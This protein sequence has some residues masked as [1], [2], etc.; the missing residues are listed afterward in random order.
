MAYGEIVSIPFMGTCSLRPVFVTNLLDL[1]AWFSCLNTGICFHW[2]T[3]WISI[4]DAWGGCRTSWTPPLPWTS[5]QRLVRTPRASQ[6]TLHGHNHANP[7]S[8]TCYSVHVFAYTQSCTAVK[9][10]PT[11]LGYLVTSRGSTHQPEKS[12]FPRAAP[13]FFGIHRDT[14]W[15]VVFNRLFQFGLSSFFILL[16][17]CPQG[18]MSYILEQNPGPVEV[19]RHFATDSKEIRI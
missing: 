1:R 6:V 4:G 10:S 18:W 13:L 17:K 9:C 7:S 19:Y 14:S 8:L 16:W 12:I 11:P 2:V 15:N 3:L 5:S